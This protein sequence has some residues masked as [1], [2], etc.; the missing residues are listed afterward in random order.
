LLSLGFI[1]FF[2]LFFCWGNLGYFSGFDLISYGLILLSLWI[3]V[4]MILAREAVF[5]SGYFSG[6][7]VFVVVVL[8]IMLYCTFRRAGLLSCYVFF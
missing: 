5:R 6:F 7:F 3:C 4:L 2:F 8:A 1:Y